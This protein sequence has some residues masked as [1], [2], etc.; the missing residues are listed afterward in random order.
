MP[1]GAGTFPSINIP[2]LADIPRW[3]II[4]HIQPIA[5]IAI[6]L[7]F[8]T[9]FI[10]F[11]TVWGLRTRSVGEHPQAADT[12]GINVFFMRYANVMIGGLLAGLA[13]CYFTLESVPYFGPL[14]TN[15]K[16]FIALAAVIFGKWNPIGAWLAVLLF[17]TAEALQVNLQI[18]G[19]DIPNQFV[20]MLPY[21]L[22]MIVL[23]G[24]VGKS[25]APAADGVPYEKQ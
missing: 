19:I 25:S 23:A 10:L 1:A 2:F 24:F 16:G 18:L 13:G 14:M 22:T 20:G 4:F 15:G 8:V 3:G 5:L 17:A 12:V 6:V 21:V 11:R 9:D 7:V